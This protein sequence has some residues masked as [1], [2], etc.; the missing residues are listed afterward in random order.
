MIKNTI[1]SKKQNYLFFIV[2]KFYKLQYYSIVIYGGEN[3]KYC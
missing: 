3:A 1:K 2:V